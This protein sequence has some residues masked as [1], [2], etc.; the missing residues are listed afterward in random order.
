MS[1]HKQPS[2]TDGS[3]KMCA[4]SSMSSV[5]REAAELIHAAQVIDAQK[6]RLKRE[7]KALESRVQ[8]ATAEKAA[9][10]T[11]ES[12]MRNARKTAASAEQLTVA[13]RHKQHTEHLQHQ[14]EEPD[15]QPEAGARHAQPSAEGQENE[16]CGCCLQRV[17]TA[18]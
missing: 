17:C 1:D 12:Q 6:A 9:A 2:E 5:Y 7:L 15:C 4:V 10:E 13:A 3:L 11:L 16:V 18:G 8:D 14:A